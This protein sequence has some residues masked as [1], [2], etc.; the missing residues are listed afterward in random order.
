MKKIWVIVSCVAC[1]GIFFF[2]GMSY[3]KSSAGVSADAARSGTPGNGTRTFAR[4][5]NGGGFVAGEILSKDAQSITIKLPNG[6]SQV[7]F[8]SAS[9][10]ITKPIQAS[11]SDL[12]AGMM[13]TVGGM[14]NPDGTL[15][16]Q[17]IQVRPTGTPISGGRNQ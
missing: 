14:T 4:G 11:S 3:G 9:T 1:A 7:V 17:A 15:T 5:G 2:I 6:N 13:I 16:A 10:A 12:S 8:Y